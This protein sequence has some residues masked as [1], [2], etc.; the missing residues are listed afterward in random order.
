MGEIPHF[1]RP[2]GS[3]FMFPMHGLAF[4]IGVF[5]RNSPK[6]VFSLGNT[7]LA[8]CSRRSFRISLLKQKKVESGGGGI[9]IWNH[10]DPAEIEA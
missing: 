1:S 2:G 10:A 8:I 9:A 7:D 4:A 3:D 5:P 6:S